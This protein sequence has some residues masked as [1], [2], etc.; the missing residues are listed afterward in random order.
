MHR[1]GK[2]LQVVLFVL[3]DS[4]QQVNNIGVLNQLLV[5]A[6]ICY[7]LFFGSNVGCQPVANGIAVIDKKL[8]K[9]VRDLNA[10]INVWKEKPPGV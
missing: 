1:L 9:P 5:L 6:V 3:D 4:L 7:C 10:I 8:L 2:E